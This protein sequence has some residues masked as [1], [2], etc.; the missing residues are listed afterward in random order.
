MIVL[1]VLT[2][3]YVFFILFL[4]FGTSKLKQWETEHFT[5]NVDFT[6][7]VPLGN[8]ENHLPVLLKSVAQLNYPKDR[9]E[10]LFINNGSE[11][12]PVAICE[13][14]FRGHPGIQGN[15][16]I[17]NPDTF[18]EET[19]IEAGIEASNSEY[20]LVLDAS[21]M[22]PKGLLA[23]FNAQILRA[24]TDM[25]VGPVA[26]PSVNMGRK[27]GFLTNFQALDL[28]G[29]QAATQGGFG[30]EKPSLSYSSNLCFSKSAFDSVDGFLEGG[31]G[32]AGDS[33]L[34]LKKFIDAGL[35]VTY[36]KNPAA[37]VRTFPVESWKGFLSRRSQETTT[38]TAS[39]HPF[40]KG[41]RFLIYLTNIAFVLGIPAMLFGLVA[42]QHYFLAFV[43]KFNADFLLLYPTSTFLGME[44]PMRSYLWCSMVYPFFISWMGL[45]ALFS[46]ILWTKPYSKS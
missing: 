25:L 16:V 30:V 3:V 8:S 19:A 35:S 1:W 42:P 13:E 6:I 4:R 36:V 39:I 29:R 37:V 15:I 12:A 23:A 34:L 27:M 5:A 20:I 26:F 28:I 46:G 33:N 24:G 2:V 22:L 14:F 43:L 10:V 41:I 7:V 21:C 9:F 32:N 11:D 17:S 31:I 44:S 45:Q 40:G 18:S 38:S